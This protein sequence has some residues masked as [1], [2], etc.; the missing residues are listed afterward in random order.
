MKLTSILAVCAIALTASTAHAE[1]IVPEVLMQPAVSSVQGRDIDLRGLLPGMSVEEARVVLTDILG[2]P[3]RESMGRTV[4]SADGVTVRGTPFTEWL[5]GEINGEKITTMFSGVSSGNQ[6]ILASREGEYRDRTSAP[7]FD[8]F[9]AGLLEK[10]GEP[11]F[12]RDMFNGAAMVWTFKDGQPVPCEA[13]GTLQ[14]PI[15][16]TMVEERSSQNFDVIVFAAVESSLH[17][18]VRA[19]RL[20]STDQSITVAADEADD[21]GLRPA[22]EAALAEA[23]A[24]APQP[25]F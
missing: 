15:P 16:S 24:N 17:D 3:P 25:V 12:R 10:Y 1:D 14:C 23:V 19:F 2:S 6:L 21:A 5:S 7:L 11:S 9:I 4:L 22:L 13:S 18:R 20:S 8:D